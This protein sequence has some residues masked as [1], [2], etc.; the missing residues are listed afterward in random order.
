VIDRAGQGLP[1]RSGIGFT[2]SEMLG[3]RTDQA[4]VRAEEGAEAILGCEW[5]REQLDGISARA[6]LWGTGV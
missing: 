3:E 1:D 5:S 4:P 6:A 2:S